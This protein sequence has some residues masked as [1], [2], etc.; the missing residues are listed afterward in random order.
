MAATVYNG[1][2]QGTGSI[3]TQTLYTNSTGKNVRIVFN[4]FEVGNTHPG[5]LAI[6]FG[7]SSNPNH[8]GGQD[9]DTVFVSAT[10]SYRAGKHLSIFRNDN[11]TVNNAYASYPSSFPLE[12]MIADGSKIS[13]KIPAQI[14]QNTNALSYNFVAITED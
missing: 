3:H 10:S 11:N 13:V 14:D 6:Y 1:V 8:N 7:P 12:M 2:L 4:F 9:L 5:E